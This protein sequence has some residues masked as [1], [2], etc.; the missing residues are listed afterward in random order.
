MNTPNTLKQTF[1]CL[2]LQTSVTQVS[3]TGLILI[4]EDLKVESSQSYSDYDEYLQ[5][6]L[7]FVTMYQEFLNPF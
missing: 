7:I 2:P 6:S 1:L 3:V 4:L 5:Q